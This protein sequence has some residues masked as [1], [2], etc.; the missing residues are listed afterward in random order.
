M[1]KKDDKLKGLEK[2][3]KIISDEYESEIIRINKLLN[4]KENQYENQ[5]DN[6][7][8]NQLSNL[9]KDIEKEFI[10]AIKKKDELINELKNKIYHLKKLCKFSY[11]ILGKIK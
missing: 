5:F 10:D 7:N 2:S 8:E 4:E 9:R 11:E 3:F 1:D 6:Q